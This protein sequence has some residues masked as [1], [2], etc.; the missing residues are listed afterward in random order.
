MYCPWNGVTRD[1]WIYAFTYHC[2]RLLCCLYVFLLLFPTPPD[3]VPACSTNSCKC[4]HPLS[5]YQGRSSNLKNFQDSLYQQAWLVKSHLG[6]N[7]IVMP[8][9]LNEDQWSVVVLQG[10]LYNRSLIYIEFQNASCGSGASFDRFALRFRCYMYWLAQAPRLHEGSCHYTWQE[11]LEIT[12]R[13]LMWDMWGAHESPNLWTCFD[14]SK[15]FGKSL[16]NIEPH[17][18]DQKRGA[19]RYKPIVPNDIWSFQTWFEL[20]DFGWH[21]HLLDCDKSTSSTEP[22]SRAF[23]CIDYTNTLFILQT[24]HMILVKFF[25]VLDM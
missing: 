18:G 23:L 11:W 3:H 6:T 5:R 4:S 20:M 14:M 13:A 10:A 15:W 25:W 24:A 19:N 8:T 22:A 2:W 1:W 21:T 9:Q 17:M 16:Q 12:H 7:R